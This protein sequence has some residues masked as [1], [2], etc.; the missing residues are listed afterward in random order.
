MTTVLITGASAGIGAAFAQELAARQM[1]L[2]WWREQ[3]PNFNNWLNNYR[4]IQDSSGR[5]SPRPQHR[6]CQSCV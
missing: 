4:T 2:V 6:S 1:N 3:T 5:F